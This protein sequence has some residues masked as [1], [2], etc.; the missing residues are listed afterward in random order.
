MPSIVISGP[1]VKEGVHNVMLR[2]AKFHSPTDRTASA[3]SYYTISIGIREGDYTDWIGSWDQSTQ[4]A[5]AAEPISVLDSG[6]TDY[7]LKEKQAVV[8]RIVSEGTPATLEGSRVNFRLARVGGRDGP[9][10]P[11]VAPGVEVAEPDSKVALAV[12][13]RQINQTLSE[14]EES[15]PLRDPVPL[16]S[17]GTFQGRLQLDS[18]TQISLQRYVGNWVDVDGEAVGITSDGLAVT[19]TDGLLTSS[20]GISATAAAATTL[21][22][23]YVD[24]T[25]LLRLSAT[26]PSAHNGVYY[27]GT[28]AG[29]RGWRFVGWAYTD[30]TPNFTDSVVSRC[31]VNYYNREWK[32]L[33]TC[34][35][36]SDNDAQTTHTTA[37]VNWSQATGVSRVNFVSNG[38]DAVVLHADGLVSND[39]ANSTDIGIGIDT[40]TDCSRAASSTTKTQN[41]IHV[42]FPDVHSAGVHTADLMVRVDGGT[43]TYV[44]DR[45]RQGATADPAATYLSGQIAV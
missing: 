42:S 33:Y 39:G 17:S 35:S 16:V 9:A 8:V 34:P 10:K 20:G 26:A 37:G 27:L 25:P 40:T 28:A 31:V 3:T 21:Y 1:T 7:R 11:L 14:W 45:P 29:A 24:N 4:I 23:A 22:Y 12:M 18:A 43:G 32:D 19:T 30:A 38:E 15:V 36:Y 44:A 5:T 41:S 13:Q 6:N 2:A